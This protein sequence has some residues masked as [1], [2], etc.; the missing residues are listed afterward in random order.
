MAFLAAIGGLKGAAALKKAKPA[1]QYTDKEIGVSLADHWSKT[2]T[3]RMLLLDEFRKHTVLASEASTLNITEGK[4][5]DTHVLKD[6]LILCGGC[7]GNRFDSEEFNFITK[8]TKVLA[9]LYSNIDLYFKSEALSGSRK[10][11]ILDSDVINVYMKSFEEDKDAQVMDAQG[12]DTVFSFS[13]SQQET[14]TEKEVTGS[15]DESA[16]VQFHQFADSYERLLFKLQSLIR[17]KQAS[18]ASK[19]DGNATIDLNNTDPDGLGD[20]GRAMPEWL[21]VL[22]QFYQENGVCLLQ[23][24]ASSGGVAC[25]PQTLGKFSMFLACIVD[26]VLTN[27]KSVE[28]KNAFFQLLQASN[29]MHI[30]VNQGHDVDILFN[31][32]QQGG[33]QCKDV[34]YWAQRF[35]AFLVTVRE[36]KAMVKDRD[37]LTNPALFSR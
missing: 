9:P 13:S 5:L 6:V 24:D 2:C 17:E 25:N 26:G 16:I 27:T 29:D 28:V 3:D 20:A 23:V 37:A 22:L 19:E 7:K 36:I 30:A 10:K 33:A 18:L 15:D 8:L 21:E 14:E 4:R 35:F 32:F 31:A 1:L 12:T 11:K 34:N